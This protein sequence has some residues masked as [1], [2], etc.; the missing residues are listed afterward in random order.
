MSFN[1]KL[2]ENGIM[3]INDPVHGQIEIK[4]PFSQI[5]LT[6][7]MQR[8]KDIG[9]NGFSI[10]DYPGLKNNERLSHSVGAFHIMSKMIEHL[11]NELSRYGISISQDD[12]DMALCSMLLHDIGHGPFSHDC[13]LITKYSHEKRT[14]DIL[15]GDTEVNELLTAVFGKRKTKKMASY[16]AEINDENNE[17]Q[18]Q[19]NSFTKLLK[20]LI[21]HQLDS[22]RLDYLVRDSYHAGIKS[23]IDYKR[24]IDALGISVNSNQDY[25]VV[26]DKTALTDLETVLIERFQRYRDVYF[27][28]STSILQVMFP[29]ILQRYAENP[30]CVSAQLPEQFKILANNPQDMSLA[31]FLT[32]TDKPFLETIETIKQ[33][34]SDPILKHLC[35]L[36]NIKEHYQLLGENVNSKDIIEKLNEIFPQADLSQTLCVF[37]SKSK[38]KVYKKEESLKIDYG[39]E[40]KDLSETTNLIRPQDNFERVRTFFNP[41]I[42]RLELGMSEIEFNQY[43]KQIK[44]MLEDINKKPEEFELKYILSDKMTQRFSKEDML[45]VLLLNGFKILSEE[46]KL[47]DDEYY[48]TKDC[49]LLAGK[50]SLRVRRLTQGD[51]KTFKA[52]LKRP[53]SQGEVYS[54]RVE[55]E[56]SLKEDSIEELKRKLSPK[57]NDFNFNEILHQPILNSV[58]ER[59]DYVLERNGIQVCFSFDNITYKNYILSSTIAEDSM[60]EIEAIGNVKDRVILNEIHEILSNRFKGLLTNKESKY[61]RGV[62]KTRENYKRKTYLDAPADDGARR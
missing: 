39:N 46:Q 47:N 23:A 28:I 40:I 30:N 25:E 37:D 33:N 14:T 5:I 13:E 31:Q 15:L 62:Q 34:T 59:K 45:K 52:T 58:T 41:E 1:Y 8:L 6:K 21:S 27:T 51:K 3:I 38:I 29:K 16:I 20:S 9:Q 2:L 54:S 24:I 60:I 53:I 18:E 17:I 48:D 56:E 49:K 12:K 22:D 10:Y 26:I 7:E 32:L 19:S 44:K 55:I 43:D 50:G 11:E 57:V 61:K 4:P 42:L 35:D 36:E